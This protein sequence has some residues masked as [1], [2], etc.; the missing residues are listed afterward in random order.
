[1]ILVA[2][3]KEPIGEMIILVAMLALR[4]LPIS[5]GF[6]VRAIVKFNLAVVYYP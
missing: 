6:C 1:M 5:L 3:E 2:D 4:P